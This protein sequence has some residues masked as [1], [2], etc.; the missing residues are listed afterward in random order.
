MI[1]NWKYILAISAS[2]TV[3][4]TFAQ[5]VQDAQRSIELERY[6]EAKANLRK[7][8]TSSPSEEV[9]FYLGDVYLKTGKVDS[10]AI[11]FN[12]G[13]AKNDKSAINMVGLGK[14]AL[15]K[16]NAAEAEKQFE[17]AVKRT[18]GKDAEILRQI[19]QAYVEAD[20]KDIT[21]GLNYLNEANKAAKNNNAA[22]YI[23]LGDLHQKN[24]NGGGEAMNAYDRAIQIDPNNAKAYLKKG[25][26]FVRSK[27]YNEAQAAFEKVIALN[28]NYAP[29]YRELGEM[30]YFVGKYDKAVENFKKYR[31]MAE[32]S[33]DTQIKYASFLF[34]T[35]DYAGTLA[36]AQ[37]VLQKDPN[38]LVMNR[39]LA[40][41]LAK[42]DKDAEALQAIENYFK[43]ADPAKVI[44]SDYAYYG[45]I[46]ASNGK[47]AEAMANLEKALAMDPTNPD[48]QNDVASAYVKAKDYPKAIAIYKTRIQAKPSLVDNFKL[49]EIYKEAG[50]YDSAD[51]LYAGIIQARPEYATAY[52]R[53]AEVAEAKDKAQTGGARTAYEEY[54]R[55][56]GQDPSKAASNKAG[57][58]KANAYLGFL[59]F[60]AKDYA[61]AR[62]YWTEAQRLDP[63]NQDI[64]NNL[65]N[66]DVLTKKKATASRK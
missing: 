42:T 30:N 57:L 11:F 59:A 65:K 7:L 44:A 43:I 2:F 14:A 20:T 16:G 4:A 52:L 6:D 41:S 58:F 5:T 64:S 19:G 38:N 32:N 25:Q 40:Y 63:N 55:V 26:L 45:R 21:K 22:V 1:K 13:L 18:K 24:P 8:N 23:T 53:R 28:P 56:A 35:E 33:V 39:L 36:E 34:L 51:S 61:N 27:N 31:S 10:A 37:Q 29:A 62:K 66:I 48:L 3:S 60:K 15:M 9:S 49:A 50:Q 54:I 12:Q 46:L 17:A 47:T